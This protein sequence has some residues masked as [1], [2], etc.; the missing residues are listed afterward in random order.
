MVTA[1]IL[2]GVGYISISIWAAREVERIDKD[3]R[4]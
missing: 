3:G 1:I 2:L 4:A